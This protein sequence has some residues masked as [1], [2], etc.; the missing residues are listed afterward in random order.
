MVQG[1]DLIGRLN[2]VE[3]K[4]GSTALL[5]AHELFR[6][7]YPIIQFARRLDYGG[8]RVLHP[9]IMLVYE[10]GF[11]GIQ[12]GIALNELFDRCRVLEAVFGPGH[13][14]LV[15]GYRSRKEAAVL[16]RH[17]PPVGSL[18]FKADIDDFI[19]QVVS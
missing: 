14:Q 9:A 16:E 12:L 11:H 10:I 8:R 19:Q 6:L 3:V 15:V 5:A 1:C 17:V 2:D 7:E 18:C 13:Q 4:D